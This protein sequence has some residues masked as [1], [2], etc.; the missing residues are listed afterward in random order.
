MLALS[1]TVPPPAIQWN[2]AGI[3]HI[4]QEN[5]SSLT[6]VL[7]SYALNDNGNMEY[8]L[9]NRALV[10]HKPKKLPTGKVKVYRN[11]IQKHCH[12]ILQKQLLLRSDQFM[13][14]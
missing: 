6:K 2:R 3:R 12:T 5:C 14:Y 10:P 1:I 13:C 7:Q 8:E 9:A 11:L 4:R